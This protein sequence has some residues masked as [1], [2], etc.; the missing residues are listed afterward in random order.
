M[1]K[2]LVN[3][4]QKLYSLT[5]FLNPFSYMKLRKN[6]Q[7]LENFSIKI[8]GILLVK[9]LQLFGFHFQRESFDMTSL[10]PVVFKQLEEQNENVFLVGATD[11]ELLKL[12]NKLLKIYPK[13]NIVGMHNGFL[14][15]NN[16]RELNEII[17]EI[18]PNIVIASMGTPRQEEFLSQ[19]QKTGFQGK[20]YT[21]GGFFSQISRGEKENYYPEWIN[22]YNL[23]AFY[24]F[25]KEPH[26]RKRLLCY[27][28]YVMVISYDLIKYKL[29]QK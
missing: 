2:T 5:T 4:Q 6:P 21:C 26:T 12:K 29:T 3:N 17:I 11:N 20:G 13:L 15:E 1:I 25:Y 27:P 23:R 9:L 8:D 7:L 28:Y 10:A 22:K 14:T 18:S 16:E 24:R 19:L